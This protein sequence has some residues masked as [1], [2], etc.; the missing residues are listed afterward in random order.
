[1]DTSTVRRWVGK[2]QLVP[3]ATTPGGHYRFDPNDVTEVL[4]LRPRS[5]SRVA[6]GVA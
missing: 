6:E 5:R 1:M 2:K 3:A 4:G